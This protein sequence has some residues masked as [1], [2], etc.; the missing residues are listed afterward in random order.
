[1]RLRMQIELYVVFIPCRL[2]LH[3]WNCFALKVLSKVHEVKRC[4][5]CTESLQILENRLDKFRS[6]QL[7]YDYKAD[8]HGIG[9]RSI[10]DAQAAVHNITFNWASVTEQWMTASRHRLDT[11]NTELMWTCTKYNALKIPICENHSLH[12]ITSRHIEE[13]D[14]GLDRPL[15]PMNKMYNKNLKSV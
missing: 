6:N 11:V 15:Y 7:L 8:L 1:M 14:A 3:C 9:N 10:L 2:C 5:D 4:T 13:T 12:H